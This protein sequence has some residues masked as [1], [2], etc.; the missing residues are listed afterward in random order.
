M[1]F[2]LRVDKVH[3]SGMTVTE[4]RGHGR[5]RGHT[6]IYRGKEYDVTLLPK[7]EVEVIVPGR[8]GRVDHQ[9]D[10]IGRSHRRNR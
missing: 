6:A 4:A 9:R 10:R 5:Q 7:M 8:S 1:A 2:P 3:V